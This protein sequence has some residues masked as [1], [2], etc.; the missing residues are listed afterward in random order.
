MSANNA[1]EAVRAALV[2]DSAVAAIVSTRVYLDEAPD[3]A[4]LPLIVYG[5]RLQ[6]ESDGSAPMSPASIDVNCYAATD[7]TAKSLAD[8][9][10][11]VMRTIGLV[12]A[13]TRVMSLS[14]EDWDSVRDAELSMWGRLLRYGAVVVR[15]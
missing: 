2:A 9:V 7:D 3:K 11:G 12:N 8:A 13:G 10:D 1:A 15:G 6:E 14:L 4:T 5:V